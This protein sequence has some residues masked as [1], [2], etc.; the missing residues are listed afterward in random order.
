MAELASIALADRLNSWLKLL[1]NAEPATRAR[2]KTAVQ[3][4]QETVLNTQT[5][6]VGLK[7]GKQ[8][9]RDLEWWDSFLVTH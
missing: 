1:L 2:W 7:R 5:Y 4:L 9:D 6:V 3:V 8:V